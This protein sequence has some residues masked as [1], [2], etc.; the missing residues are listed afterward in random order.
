MTR[1]LCFSDSPEPFFLKSLVMMRSPMSVRVQKS[2]AV[3]EA[4][5]IQY[6]SP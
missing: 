4:T 3:V 1:D 5:V 6:A 2:E